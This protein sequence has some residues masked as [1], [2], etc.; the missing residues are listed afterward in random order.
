MSRLRFPALLPLLLAACPAAAP[1]LESRELAPPAD[2]VIAPFA[3]EVTDAA[4]LEGDRWVVISPQDRAVQVV[5]F[6]T[7][8]LAPFPPRARQELDQ[9][10]HLFR[11]GDTIFVADW[12]RRRLTGW[13]LR[14]APAGVLP[15]V[16]RFRGA[17]P[18]ARDAAGR[19]YFELRP[20]PGPDGS[21]NR[22]SAAIVRTDLTGPDDTVA[23]L[24]PFDLAE[25]LSEG[26]RRLERRLLSGQDR[27]GIR[28]DGTLWVARVAENR[29]EWR[30]DS[31]AV[32]LGHQLP[33][34]VLPVTE[35]D[36][37]LFLNRFDA[38]LRPTV[39]QI[40]FAAIKAPFEGATLDPDGQL[41]LTKSRAIGDSLR[42]YQVVDR[43]GALV[44]EVTHRGLGHVLA[45]SPT[46]LLVAEPIEHGVRLLRFRLNPPAP[47][48]AATP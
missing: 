16:D 48:G 39:A 27:W 21:G 24:A 20:P 9:P 15:A 26:R 41:W 29:V 42:Y 47:A 33:D 23:R 17:L 13:S 45:I 46:D 43:T 34:R 11:S 2:T 8:A 12:Q 22:D 18:R 32:E 5:D 36:R 3:G 25:V 44:R 37:E 7:Q 31:G 30:A 38:G 19:W 40:P 28:P 35:N 1:P 6:G 14:G 4:W 10:F